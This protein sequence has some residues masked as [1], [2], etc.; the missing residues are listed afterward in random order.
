MTRVYV[1]IGS[2]IEREKNID[3]GLAAL[4][5]HYGAIDISPV[6][7]ARSVGF[8]GD[9][10]FNLVAA[11]DTSKDVDEVEKELRQIEYVHGRSRNETRFS[12]RTLDIDLLLYNGL[13]SKKHKIPR[14][15]ITKYAFVIKPL[16][17]L[18]PDLVHPETGQSIAEIWNTFEFNQEELKQIEYKPVQ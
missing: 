10:F 3:G 1:G 4:E 12:S 17:D 9:D 13:V 15:D 14:E 6:Y 2:N 18:A 7:E 5:S 11:F 16:F 8:E